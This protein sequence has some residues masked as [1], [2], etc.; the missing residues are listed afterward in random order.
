M[1]EVIWLN[2]VNFFG[3]ITKVDGG[4]F[5]MLTNPNADPQSAYAKKNLERYRGCGHALQCQRQGGPE[6]WPGRSNGR[7]G[8]EEWNG[9]GDTLD[10]V[11]RESPCSDGKR[12]GAAAKR[13]TEVEVTMNR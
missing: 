2:I 12:E 7:A 11:R 9:Q 4:G 6:G 5:E 13:T 1:A 3:V 8:F 10:G